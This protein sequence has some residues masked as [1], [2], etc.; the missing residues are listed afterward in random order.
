VLSS[1][2]YFYAFAFV[3]L[4]KFLQL[5]KARKYAMTIAVIP[6]KKN[7]LSSAVLLTS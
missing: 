2:F 4:L 6:E 5:M 1:A 3:E 7:M